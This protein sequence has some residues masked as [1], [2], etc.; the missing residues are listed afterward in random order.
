MQNSLDTLPASWNE[1]MMWGTTRPH[2]YAGVRSRTGPRFIFADVLWAKAPTRGKDGADGK[3]KAP[4]V[5]RHDCKMEDGLGKY[6]WDRHNGVSF[7]SQ[8]ILDPKAGVG[9]DVSF[10][11]QHH[12]EWALGV[13]NVDAEGRATVMFAFGCGDD[14]GSKGKKVIEAPSTTLASTMTF[15]GLGVSG[16]CSSRC[17]VRAR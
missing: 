1:G 16:Q 17:F 3:A 10:V 4:V 2:V 9:M 14:R 15:A 11:K 12:G 13:S 6:G 7:G 8:T 5:L